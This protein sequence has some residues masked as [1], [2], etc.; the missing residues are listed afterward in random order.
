MFQF[1]KELSS[2]GGGGGGSKG[3]PAVSP[4]EQL[5]FWRIVLD[6]AQLVSTTNSVAAQ[7]AAR[8]WR[9]HAWVVTGTP[10][11]GSVAELHGLLTFLA[12]EYAE[13]SEWKAVVHD[14]FKA[15][16]PAGLVRLRA[17]LRSVMLRR[18]KDQPHIMRQMGLPPLTWQ[19]LQL[20]LQA[21]PERTAYQKAAKDLARSLARFK[22][23]ADVRARK[24]AVGYDGK[25][26]AA[27]QYGK[28]VG[29]VIRL[30]QAACATMKS[31]LSRSSTKTFLWSL[32]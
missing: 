3:E 10:I 21:G 31:N 16:T 17:L 27:K 6:E 24:R 18:T 4:L 29:D 22:P 26:K 28:F 12:H 9:R 2:A 5:G 1:R 8:L 30:R 14:P 20:E 11:S 19:A 15:R 13:P 32:D 7:M 25:N 23:L